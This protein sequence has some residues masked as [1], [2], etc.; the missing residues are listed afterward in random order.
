[1]VWRWKNHD[2]STPLCCSYSPL[3]EFSVSP[4]T[5][6]FPQTL[7]LSSS[8]SPLLHGGLWK[9][10]LNTP[11]GFFF[12]PLCCLSVENEER[13]RR[14]EN[15]IIF[16][17]TSVFSSNGNRKWRDSPLM[18]LLH[19]LRRHLLTHSHSRRDVMSQMRGRLFI[20]PFVSTLFFTFW[21][22]NLNASLPTVRVCGCLCA[23]FISLPILCVCLGV[24]QD[25]VSVLASKKDPYTGLKSLIKGWQ[26]FLASCV[27]LRRLLGSSRLPLFLLPPFP[28]PLIPD[29]WRGCR[30]ALFFTRLCG[31]V[32]HSCCTRRTCIFVGGMRF[33]T[34]KSFSSHCNC[35]HFLFLTMDASTQMGDMK[36]L[37][38]QSSK[39]WGEARDSREGRKEK[40]VM[41]IF[42]V[43]A[44][45]WIIQYLPNKKY[46]S[47]ELPL[48][49]DKHIMK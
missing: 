21:Y 17:V 41:D 44:Q 9:G 6:I 8:L 10:N 26:I 38:H 25:C 7:R 33:W 37:W 16:F 2:E 34:N 31:D 11:L 13:E 24:V 4:Y 47:E 32:L 42:I 46:G 48:F 30:R 36:L 3:A 23:L 14:C 15:I 12:S 5:P 49:W 35:L 18:R 28:T 40:I 22:T 20:S 45:W 29:Y 27:V 1:M 19:S 43:R 39:A